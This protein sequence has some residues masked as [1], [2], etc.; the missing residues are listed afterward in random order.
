[1]A[2]R[3]RAD[4][5]D[6]LDRRLAGIGDDGPDPHTEHGQAVLWPPLWRRSGWLAH[7]HPATGPKKPGPTLG[8]DRRWPEASGHH[9]VELGPKSRFVGERFGPIHG[10]GRPDLE[11][12]LTYGPAQELTPS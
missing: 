6:H 10:N 2:V 4:L 11:S 7:Q 1:V 12:Q 9:Q 8:C 5:L 3:A